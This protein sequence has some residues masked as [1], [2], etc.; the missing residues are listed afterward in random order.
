MVIVPISPFLFISEIKCSILAIS[1]VQV[2]REGDIDIIIY[3]HNI[4]T[5]DIKIHLNIRQPSLKIHLWFRNV[6]HNVMNHC[7]S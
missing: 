6:P 7:R 4:N 2:N 1:E 5:S 3:M